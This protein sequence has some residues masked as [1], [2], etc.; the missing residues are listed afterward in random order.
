M[1]RP[2]LAMIVALNLVA[3]VALGLTLRYLADAPR[4]AQYGFGASML[5]LLGAVAGLSAIGLVTNTRPEARLAGP[6]GG[7]ERRNSEHP[8]GRRA[9]DREVQSLYDT[10]A[11]TQPG[12]GLAAK[13]KAA[14]ALD[15]EPLEEHED[16]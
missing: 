15:L 13:L 7:V 3:F 9:I 4:P 6:P 10:I 14:N 12:P 16:A 11:Q 1:S 5:M 2:L 8:F